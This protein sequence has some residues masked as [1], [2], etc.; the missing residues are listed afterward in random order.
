MRGSLASGSGVRRDTLAL[1]YASCSYLCAE[2]CREFLKIH[3]GKIFLKDSVDSDGGCYIVFELPVLNTFAFSNSA[4]N[5]VR[6]RRSATEWL[7]GSF[8]NL[9]KYQSVLPSNTSSSEAAARA[10][11]SSLRSIPVAVSPSDAAPA[12]ELVE[13]IIKK[14]LIVDDSETTVKLM[15]RMLTKFVDRSCIYSALNGLDCLKMVQE[16]A[17][18]NDPF[19]LVMIDYVMEPINGPDTVVTM[20]QRGF[21]GVIVGVTGLT[22]T[23]IMMRF[24]SSG[25]DKALS[26]PI[27]F[28]ILSKALQGRCSHRYICVSM[29]IYYYLM[30]VIPLCRNCH[31]THVAQRL[32]IS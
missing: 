7:V 1:L 20:R 28:D 32:L 5:P 27:S 10:E 12:P 31:A 9:R 25:A 4:T 17:E 22:E 18:A 15:T 19:D 30:R 2:V 6:L 16:A 21:T 29:D 26:K 8:T 24:L 23:S 11:S 13:N 14:V 3:G